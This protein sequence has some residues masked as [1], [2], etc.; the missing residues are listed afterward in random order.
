MPLK[1]MR[2][3]SAESFIQRLDPCQLLS[4]VAEVVSGVEFQR[5]RARSSRQFKGVSQWT[6]SIELQYAKPR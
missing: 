6:F 2:D 3:L 1:H 5:L 4:M